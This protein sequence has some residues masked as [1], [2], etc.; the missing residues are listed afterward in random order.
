M[1]T[2]VF[3]TSLNTELNDGSRYARAEFH[4]VDYVTGIVTITPLYISESAANIVTDAILI[5]DGQGYF[6]GKTSSLQAYK[7]CTMQYEELYNTGSAFLISYLMPINY[8]NSCSR[9]RVAPF[10]EQAFST[11]GALSTIDPIYMVNSDLATAAVE[12]DKLPSY[13]DLTPFNNMSLLERSW[14]QQLSGDIT[15]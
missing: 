4:D 12:A 9:D 11:T 2:V 13:S 10:A 3:D 6:A 8:E 1:N 7:P 15:F 5:S 14:C